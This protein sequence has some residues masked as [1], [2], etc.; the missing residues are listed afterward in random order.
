MTLSLMR[1]SEPSLAG[2]AIPLSEHQADD[3]YSSVAEWA[4]IRRALRIGIHT[5]LAV[6]ARA[7]RVGVPFQAELIASGI[8]SEQDFICAL[9][10]YLQ[11]GFLFNIKAEGLIITEEQSCQALK[12]KKGLPIVSAL[13]RS[14]KC[15]LLIAP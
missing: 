3:A 2:G 7:A 13:D 9:A 8:V 5:W 4:P 1:A 14:G 12:R 11:V 10:K 6:A 15:V